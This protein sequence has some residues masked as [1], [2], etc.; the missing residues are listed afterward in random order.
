MPDVVIETDPPTPEYRRVGWHC[1]YHEQ[2][3][4][5]CHNPLDCDLVPVWALTVEAAKKRMGV[6][7]R[8]RAIVGKRVRVKDDTSMY[9]DLKYGPVSRYAGQEGWAVAARDK[10][11]EIGVVW[12]QDADSDWPTHFMLDELEIVS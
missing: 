2:A 12:S 3:G 8:Q 7:R 5:T 11:Y 4:R 10:E 1:I 9:A 6:I